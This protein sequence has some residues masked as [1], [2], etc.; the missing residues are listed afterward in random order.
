MGFSA[1]ILSKTKEDETIKDYKLT[2][3]VATIY[4][5]YYNIWKKIYMYEHSGF[6]FAKLTEEEKERNFLF[7]HIKKEK[8]LLDK[9]KGL[10]KYG[11][12]Y[13][14][15]EFYYDK[16]VSYLSDKPWVENIKLKTKQ[17]SKKEECKANTTSETN[18]PKDTV[19]KNFTYIIQDNNKPRLLKRLHSL[20]DGKRGAD[21]GAILLKAYLDGYLMRVPTQ[22]EYES[23]FNLI[24]SWEA[25]RKYLDKE[26]NNAILKVQGISIFP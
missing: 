13:D 26:S 3:D 11:Q 21:V 23:E 2:E 14:I 5:K 9:S 19:K 22:A 12:L 18:K 16:Y 24:G 17:E 25:I 6:K 1:Y 4:N 7:E 8:I 15:A 20:I 10:K